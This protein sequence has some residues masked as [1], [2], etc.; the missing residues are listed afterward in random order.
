M[1]ISDVKPEHLDEIQAIEDAC[2]SMPWTRA[3]LEHQMTANNCVFLAALDGEGTV[4][5]YVGLMFVLDEGYISNVAVAPEY[6]RRGV[7][8]ALIYAL[9]EREK[10]TLSFLTLEVRESNL[11]AISLYSKHGFRTVGTRRN[12]YD[13]PKENALLMTLFFDGKETNPCI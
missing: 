9:I 3:S 12:Y 6:R 13:R 7:A 10:D 8:D 5:G 1:T 2:F 4:M 11:P